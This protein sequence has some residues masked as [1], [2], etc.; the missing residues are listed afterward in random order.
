VGGGGSVYN[1]PQHSQSAASVLW[2]KR[3]LISFPVLSLL[4][5]C[6]SAGYKRTS[7]A[8]RVRVWVEGAQGAD[9]KPAVLSVRDRTTDRLGS[10]THPPRRPEWKGNNYL[11]MLNLYEMFS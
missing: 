6:F 5:L 2:A 9:M 4:S 7:E 1:K 8:C 10:T 11:E 3:Q